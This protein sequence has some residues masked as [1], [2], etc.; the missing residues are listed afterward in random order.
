[1]RV[2]ILITTIF[3]SPFITKGQF[4]L[5]FGITQA[6]F[7]SSLGKFMNE[8]FLLNDGNNPRHDKRNYYNYA[9]NFT[10]EFESKNNGFNKVQF[11]IGHRNIKEEYFDEFIDVGYKQTDSENTTYNQ[12]MYILNYVYEK[13]IDISK[14]KFGIGLGASIQR[15]GKG[16]QNYYTEFRDIGDGGSY[17]LYE[18]WDYNITTAG[19]WAFGIVGSISGEYKISD[20]LS[21]GLDLQSYLSFLTF[22]ENDH[23]LGS[24]RTNSSVYSNSDIDL[25]SKNNFRRIS[26]SQITP[27]FHISVH[28]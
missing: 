22:T 24:Y 27:N 10:G 16:Y 18:I 25:Y 1:M 8:E 28:F 3:L 2:Y 11:I 7:Y 4:N 21:I 20:K 15:I 17:D 19:G 6:P 26:T 13:K 14:I 5:E 12:L 23:V 9:V